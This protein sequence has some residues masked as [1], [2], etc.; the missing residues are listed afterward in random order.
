[1]SQSVNANFFKE[2][3]ALSEAVHCLRQSLKADTYRLDRMLKAGCPERIEQAEY[4]ASSTRAAL[5][6][7]EIMEAAA[8]KQY[9]SPSVR[10]DGAQ[11]PE[12]SQV[13]V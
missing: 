10:T 9:E 8:W 12:L 5:M 11:A 2:T 13:S 4:L 6:K 3:T 7:M 1:M